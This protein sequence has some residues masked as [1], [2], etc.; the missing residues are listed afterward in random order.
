MLKTF[1]P[2]LVCLFLV[3]PFAHATDISGS[4][5]QTLSNGQSG[6]VAN[7]ETLND[8][9]HNVA[10]AVS[11]TVTID[12]AGTIE[13]T[14]TNSDQK[15]RGIR[16][17]VGVASITL[18]NESTGLITT[19]DADTVQLTNA[20]SNET[21][22][23]YGTIFSQNT[24]SS[25]SAN[26]GNGQQAI[27]FSN[28]TSGSTTIYNYTTGTIKAFDSDAIKAGANGKIYNYGT[29]YSYEPSGD[30]NGNDGIDA[31]TNSGVVITNGDG[32]HAAT[33]EGARHGITGG[34]T[35][36]GV[37]SMNITNNAGGTI[38]GDDGSGVNI[39]GINGSETVTIVNSGT[40]TG[41]GSAIA[42]GDTAADG[43]GVDVDG[44]VNLT[45]Y[46][47]IKSLDAQNDTSEG[48]TVGGGM[49]TNEAHAL[50]EGDVK[51]GNTTGA[52]GVGITLAGVDKS[53]TTT[54]P[55]QGIYAA[56]SVDN[57]GTIR[58]QTG[59]GIQ[60]TST[61]ST[62][63]ITITNEAGGLIEGNSSTGAA[64][65][66]DGAMAGV[67]NKLMNYGTIKNDTGG[68]AIEL[69]AGTNEV[70]IMG[71]SAEVDGGIS[72]GIGSTNSLFTV[73]AGSGNGFTYS[74]T[75]TNFA[76]VQ[77]ESGTFTF[78][79]TI[80][81]TTTTTIQT[82]ATLAGNGSV[83]ALVIAANG[84]LSPGNSPGKVS[85]TSAVLNPMGNFLL[86][87]DTDGNTGAAGTNWDQLAV[88]GTVDVT[89][90]SSSGQFVFT[91]QSLTSTDAAG[92]L[93]SFNPYTNHVWKDVVTSTGFV[94]TPAS[95]NFT[96][97][98]SQFTNPLDGSFSI[99]ID[100]TSFDLVYT[101]AP[102]PSVW[103]MLIVGVTVLLGWR[104]RPARQA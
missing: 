35:S 24:L 27:D 44:L 102:E 31:G 71:G 19:Y 49:I 1:F 74:G 66:L 89:A 50:I 65:Q 77:I 54:I 6:T 17:D 28:V 75:I 16:D 104:M 51:A 29:V 94:G 4:G 99:A 95:S 88:G 69:G 9:S 55:P 38:Q 97:N 68:Q 46:G 26:Y 70:D 58:G 90:L 61:A 14:N 63:G 32:T 101:A 25:N 15:E 12:N 64:V 8:S 36:T 56:S 22:Y 93:A 5:Q 98:S 30:V 20:T 92:S 21:V 62:F 13:Q 81:G 85:A 11:G 96:V 34:N 37:Y 39:D 78:G 73:Q 83:G 23:N 67:A 100:G 40:I 84:T 79:G 103:L 18:T 52:T 45:N 59:A 87:V 3:D 41:N 82:G 57:Y 43:D 91:L 60:A 42:K 80:S 72:G 53:G 48:V 76:K 7:G 86:Q 33:I 2:I 47:T 10:V